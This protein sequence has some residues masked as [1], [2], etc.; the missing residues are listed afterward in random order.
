MKENQLQVREILFPVLFLAVTVFICI[1]GIM[2]LTNSHEFLVKYIQALPCMLIPAAAVFAAGLGAG[3]L[4]RKKGTLCGVYIDLVFGFT[5]G[6]YIQSNILNSRLS[7]LDGTEM[8]WND[9]SKMSLFSVAVW[10]ACLALPHILRRLAEGAW[11]KICLYGSM[12]LI[13]MQTGSLV[14]LILSAPN[15]I[16]NSWAL[17]KENEFELS[18][19]RNTVVFVVDTLDAQWA[20]KHVLSEPDLK[21]DLTDFTYFDNVVSGG[22]PTILGMPAMLTG[23][24]YGKTNEY[25]E[26]IREANERNP[27][28]ADLKK[29]GVTIRM[30]TLL[31]YLDGTDLSLIDNAI[32]PEE[33][34]RPADPV[35]F[36]KSLYKLTAFIGMPYPLK[37]H[38][39]VYTGVLTNNAKLVNTSDEGYV[40]DDPQFYRDFTARGITLSDRDAVFALYHLKGA[41][42]PYTMDENAQGV[43]EGDSDLKKQIRGSMKII[44]EFIAEMKEKDL[45]D[46]STIIITADHGG[47]A[48]YQNPAVFVKAAGERHPFRTNSAPLTFRNLRA[49]FAASLAAETGE[50]YGEGMF[51]VDEA[52]EVPARRHTYAAV[53]HKRVFPDQE[54]S[55]SGW[56]MCEVGNPARN[57]RLIVPEEEQPDSG[58]GTVDSTGGP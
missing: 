42:G 41:H 36:A 23:E 32:R 34:Y 48:L 6:M 7:Q 53:L 45:Y 35:Q 3:W 9:G 2:F 47:V 24:I 52:A 51:D 54:V 10:I 43:P 1:P 56:L 26:F 15:D 38:F 16:G 50:E 20:E 4:I 21:E 18:A 11:R 39:V 46:R 12:L 17:T 58:T 28:F 13:I 14:P 8:V 40:L 33:E 29:A 27:L 37:K 5:M 22:A 19:N 30:Y 31:K 44:S 57:N 49:T 55:D 25:R